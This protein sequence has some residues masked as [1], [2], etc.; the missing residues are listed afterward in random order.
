VDHAQKD[1]R[2]LADSKGIDTISRSTFTE[3]AERSRPAVVSP[4]I[5]ESWFPVPWL[6]CFALVSF[7]LAEDDFDSA[8]EG[9]G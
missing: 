4:T 9:A 7:L 2:I 6:L 1:R 3:V 8:G 5:L